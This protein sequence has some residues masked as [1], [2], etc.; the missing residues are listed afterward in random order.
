MIVDI[1]YILLHYFH[2]Q[3]VLKT[4]TQEDFN[5]IT[6]SATDDNLYSAMLFIDNHL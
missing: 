3:I 5:E 4:K 6:V 1:N 2:W